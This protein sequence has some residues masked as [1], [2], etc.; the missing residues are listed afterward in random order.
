MLRLEHLS[1]PLG[2]LGSERLITSLGGGR[3]S[4]KLASAQKQLKS[5]GVWALSF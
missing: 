2:L 5:E 1:I 4:H 3:A